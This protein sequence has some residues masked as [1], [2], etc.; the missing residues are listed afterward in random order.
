MNFNIF[1]TIAAMGTCAL[2]YAVWHVVGVVRESRRIERFCSSLSMNIDALKVRNGGELTDSERGSY[3]QIRSA[4]VSYI[5]G[6]SKYK[7]KLLGSLNELCGTSYS[8]FDMH[9][10]FENGRVNG[11]FRDIV[12]RSGFLFV[13]L[14][15]LSRMES[16]GIDIEDN[17]SIAKYL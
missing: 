11:F 4:Y 7:A 5:R 15:Y 13:N 8:L 2:M 17:I 9:D 1:V 3:E 10:C 6:N 14:V 16:K 12:T